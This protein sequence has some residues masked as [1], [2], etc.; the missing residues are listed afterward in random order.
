MSETYSPW[1]DEREQAISDNADARRHE[2]QHSVG[3]ACERAGYP[4]QV[5]V[6][7]EK[8]AAEKLYGLAIGQGIAV[9]VVAAR[10]LETALGIL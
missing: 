10:F 3:P 7:L 1:R 4:I 5:I 2:K 6:S 8:E 9:E